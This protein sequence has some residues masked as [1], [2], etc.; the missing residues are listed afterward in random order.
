MLIRLVKDY[1]TSLVYETLFKE[2]VFIF[3][4][5]LPQLLWCYYRLQKADGKQIFIKRGRFCTFTIDHGSRYTS[6][7]GAE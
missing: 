5:C 1:L 7:E 2:I 6:N 4:L 3:A